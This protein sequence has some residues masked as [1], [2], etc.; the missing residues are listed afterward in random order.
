MP[1][2]DLKGGHSWNWSL[3]AGEQGPYS[4]NNLLLGPFFKGFCDAV[5]GAIIQK[6]I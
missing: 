5:E 1:G 2:N 6:I 4:Q 3:M